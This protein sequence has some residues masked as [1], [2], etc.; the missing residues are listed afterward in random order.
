MHLIVEVVQQMTKST[1]DEV[2]QPAYLFQRETMV[3]T[4][5]LQ[6]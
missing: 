3:A 1:M 2:D 6:V 5:T 4:D